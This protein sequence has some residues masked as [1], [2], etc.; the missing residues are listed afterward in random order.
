MRTNDPATIQQFLLRTGVG[1]VKTPTQQFPGVFDG[2][3]FDTD[4]TNSSLAAGTCR[5][6]IPAYSG[7]M[8]MGPVIYPGLTAPPNLTKCTVGFIAPQ[9]GGTAAVAARILTLL[10]VSENGPTGSTGPTGPS[11]GTGP[12]GYTGPTGTVPTQGAWTSFTPAWTAAGTNPTLGN[13]TATGSYALNG[14]TLQFR[15]RIVAGSTTTYGTGQY[16]LGLPTGTAASSGNQA[17]SGTI[18]S[19]L[20]Y[21]PCSGLLAAGANKFT[22]LAPG[23]GS[24]SAMGSFTATVPATFGNGDMISLQGTVELA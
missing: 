3:V 5:V 15:M 14:K 23:S 10:G 8:A 11:G 24:T 1:G 7:D 21:F 6:I 17:I 13:G 16:A 18:S 9:A 2:Y 22:L 19:S 4:A 12:T 20:A